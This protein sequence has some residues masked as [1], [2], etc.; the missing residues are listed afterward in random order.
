MHDPQA[1]SLGLELGLGQKFVMPRE[2]PTS[3]DEDKAKAELGRLVYNGIGGPL[4]RS[5]FEYARE[6]VEQMDL[7]NS[8]CE[9]LREWATDLKRRMTAASATG[10]PSGHEP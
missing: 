9:S 6:I 5:R 7:L 2:W 10:P 3:T 4:P 1:F 8:R